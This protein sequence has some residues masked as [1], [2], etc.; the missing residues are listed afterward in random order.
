[1]RVDFFLVILIWLGGIT[2]SSLKLTI[3]ATGAG[4]GGGTDDEQLLT[5]MGLPLVME[6]HGPSGTRSKGNDCG[7]GTEL[8]PVT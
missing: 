1:M 5:T 2:G 7:A 8:L 6:T 4:G 3:R